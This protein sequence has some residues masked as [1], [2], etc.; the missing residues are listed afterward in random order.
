MCDED[1]VADIGCVCAAHGAVVDRAGLRSRDVAVV[2]FHARTKDLG[3]VGEHTGR[4]RRPVD[5]ARAAIIKMYTISPKFGQ[6][7]IVVCLLPVA[8]C[9]AQPITKHDAWAAD[10]ISYTTGSCYGP[11]PAY[12]VIVSANG[13]GSFDGQLYT[14]IEGKRRFR[15]TAAQFKAFSDALQ[16]F[17]PVGVQRLESY[18]ECKEVWTDSHTVE[19]QWTS[20]MKMARLSYYYGCDPEKYKVMARA[21]SSAPERL[22][23]AEFVGQ[24][25]R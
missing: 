24:E 10:T 18:P 9:T 3:A 15:L 23:I 11:C 20:K 4:N 13:Q 17:R 21:L 25:G 6:S 16:S 14:K 2:E 1:G 8:A 22:P 19:I 7:V 12:T 5:L